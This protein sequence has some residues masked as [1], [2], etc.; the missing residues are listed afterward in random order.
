MSSFKKIKLSKKSMTVIKIVYP[1]L[2]PF[3]TYGDVMDL[4]KKH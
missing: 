4:F 2:D 1:E 3:A